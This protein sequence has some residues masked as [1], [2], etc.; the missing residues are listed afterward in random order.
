MTPLTAS[1][2]WRIVL[3]LR[4]EPA[5]ATAHTPGV[6]VTPGGGW[7]SARAADAEA[8]RILDTLLPIAHG[9]ADLVVAQ[10]GQSLDGFIATASGDSHY[11][12]GPQSR[13]HLHRLRALVDAVVVGVG[14]VV[15]DDPELTVRHVQ[16]P[17]PARVVFDPHG[18]APHAA[19]VFNDGAAPTWH[20][21]CDP[22]RAAPGAQALILGGDD[23]P[24]AAARQLLHALCGRG[25][26][27][28]LIEGGGVTVSRCVAAGLVDRLHL[29]VAPL[30]L[31]S[32]RP[33]LALP[34]ITS[35]DDALRP[36]CRCY[37]LGEDRLYELDLRRSPSATAAAP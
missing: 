20:A 4:H 25:L 28:T 29:M 12:T 5:D 32:G 37:A 36:T 15:A 6:Q 33:A 14:T 10:M 2:A 11:V 7:R 35:L 30:L 19:R 16:G 17:N 24:D 1:E 9:A 26:R 3:A 34:E 18:R 27:R 13:V 21:V 22:A 31:G 23:R 8:T